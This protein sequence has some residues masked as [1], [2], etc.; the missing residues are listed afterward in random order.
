MTSLFRSGLTREEYGV[1]EA[2]AH[3]FVSELLAPSPILLLLDMRL[4][5]WRINVLCDISPE[6]SWKKMMNLYRFRDFSNHVLIGN[7]SNYIFSKGYVE[8][9][10]TS[11]RARIKKSHPLFY[12]IYNLCRV[13]STCGAYVENSDYYRCPWCGGCIEMP[14]RIGFDYLRGFDHPVEGQESGSMMI[15]K[16]RIKRLFF[17]IE[18]NNR[19]SFLSFFVT[20]NWPDVG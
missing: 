6:A 8:S 18:K 16:N 19:A 11:L 10:Y 12:D 4:D 5:S 3:W 13:C 1:L 7:Y 14:R 20:G 17:S 9:L 15:F 2:E